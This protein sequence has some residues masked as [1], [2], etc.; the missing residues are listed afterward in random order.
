MGKTKIIIDCDPGQDDAIALLMAFGSPDEIE[1]LAVTAVAGNVPLQLTERNALRITELARRSDVPVHAGCSRPLLRSLAT[2]ENVH[3]ATGLDGCG[4]PDPSQALAP[5]HAVDAI[6]DILRREPEGTVTLCPMGPLTNIALGMV[7]EPGVL[8]RT[9]QIVLMGGAMG[10]GNVTPSAEFNFHVDPHAA[11]IVFEFGVPITMFGL[12][13]THK[14]LVTDDRLQA[15]R[16]VGNRQAEAAFGMLEFYNRYDRERY[17]SDGGPLHDPCVIAWLLQP[18]LFDGRDCHVQIE[19][20][21]ETSTGRSIVDWWQSAIDRPKNARVMCDVDHDGFFA[22]L[23][24]TLA[25]Y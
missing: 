21:S 22:L 1:V 25:S 11:R 6:I 5:G 9:R 24:R 2:A 18:E 17:R 12:D 15:V 23:T 19:T 13:V 4:L 14:V 10:L 8:A 7:K 20:E 3:G 16:A